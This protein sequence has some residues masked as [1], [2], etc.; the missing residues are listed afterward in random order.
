[1]T[2]GDPL[3]GYAL[4]RFA[5]RFGRWGPSEVNVV[6][7]GF[8]G[9]ALIVG[10]LRDG[11]LLLTP[12]GVGLLRHP[13]IWWFLI[14]QAWLPF[15]IRAS[16]ATFRKLADGKEATLS[17]EYLT[18]H[19]HGV[20]QFLDK[21]LQRGTNRSRV[22]YSL[23]ILVGTSAWAWNTYSNQHPE[24]VGFDFWD[25]SRHFWGYFL[26]RFYKAYIWL[27]LIPALVHIQVG[28]ILT[29]RRLLR[30]ATAHRGIVLQPFHPDGAGGLRFF[31]ATALNPMVPTVFIASMISLSAVLVHRRYDV[32]TVGGL[33]LACF[34]FVSLYFV[35]GTALRDAI[36]HEKERQIAEIAHIQQ[37]L[38]MT[39]SSDVS[40]ANL[41]D[42]VDAMMSLSA[43]IERIRSISEWPQLIRVVR[44]AT[45][46]WTSPS[47]LWLANKLFEKVSAKLTLL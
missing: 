23:F 19:F 42:E 44:L 43:V 3:A 36:R 16:V 29:V 15:V 32:T 20:S 13:G 12:G 45:V 35:P 6:V 33:T 4:F 24:A 30:D 21:W 9:M 39:L 7:A 2:E 27:C 8:F 25:S 10:S 28:I 37:Q 46:A 31:I 17:A 47:V 18:K 40:R 41:H 1:M 5:G 11:A 26:T 34:V 38:Y 14:G 22:S